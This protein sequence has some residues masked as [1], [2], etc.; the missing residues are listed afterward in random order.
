MFGK[1]G[2]TL[3][4]YTLLKELPVTDEHGKM[5][6]SISDLVISQ[7]GTIVGFLV[8]RKALFKKHRFLPLQDVVMYDSQGIVTSH[9]LEDS[10]FID[11]TMYTL[12]HQ[13]A[14]SNKM[15]CND[16][17]EELGLLEDVYFSEQLGTIVAYEISNGFFS[18]ITDGKKT[19]H[20]R[21]PPTLGEDTIEISPI[22]Y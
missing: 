18:D 12:L 13:R 16:K 2:C 17:G 11:D 20:A 9:K 5:I 6:G 8:S 10:S 22:M 15:I 4:T 1:A 21:K 7:T 3:R 19:V 14:I